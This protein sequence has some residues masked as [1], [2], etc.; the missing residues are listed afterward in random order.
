MKCP[1]CGSN[2]AQQLL[3]SY[4]CP[5]KTCINYDIRQTEAVWRESI[6]EQEKKFRHEQAHKQMELAITQMQN[7]KEQQ[8][9]S[10]MQMELAIAQM[11]NSNEQK[12]LQDQD[13]MQ[14][15]KIRHA[16][17]MQMN[18]M[19]QELAKQEDPFDSA[20]KE[21]LQRKLQID[22][23]KDINMD[24]RSNPAWSVQDFFNHL[25]AKNKK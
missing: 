24:K 5:N 13:Y 20:I 9:Q 22:M 6:R 10:Q 12:M 15:E 8:A 19:K 21:Y 14:M 1:E 16:T 18:K 4:L 3:V 2:N 7:S 11:R 17:Q 25:I 23:I